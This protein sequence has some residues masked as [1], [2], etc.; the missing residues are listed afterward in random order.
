MIA[1]VVSFSKEIDGV[2]RDLLINCRIDPGERGCATLPGGDPGYPDSPPE[3]DPDLDTIRLD[4]S[5]ERR[6]KCSLTDE[7]I[8]MICDLALEQAAAEE[9]D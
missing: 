1:V 5:E 8:E 3:V 6:V 4:S 9:G 7:E 2:V